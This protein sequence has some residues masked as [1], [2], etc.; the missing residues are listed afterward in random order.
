MQNPYERGPP[1]DA[2][3]AKGEAESLEAMRALIAKEPK[4]A[5]RIFPY[6]GGEEG[7]GRERRARENGRRAL[8]TWRRE[9]WTVP[10]PRSSL[11]RQVKHRARSLAPPAPMVWM[12]TIG[13]RTGTP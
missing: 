9:H 8:A 13:T 2:A 4:N 7:G 3:A 1:H 11:L 12:S 6:I 5:E 10:L